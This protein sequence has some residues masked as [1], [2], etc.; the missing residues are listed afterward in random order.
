MKILVVD[1]GGIA[2]ENG[3][4]WGN[5]STANF[6]NELKE[7]GVTLTYVAGGGN[8]KK[9]SFLYSYNLTD[10][11]IKCHRVIGGRKNPLRYIRLGLLFYHI[12]KTDFV[13]IFYPGGLSKTVHFFCN[14]IGRK[15]GLYIRG[16]GS[17]KND[18]KIIKNAQF[19]TLLASNT[20]EETSK[21]NSKTRIIKPMMVFNENDSIGIKS[22][23]F[24]S[25]NKYHFL[26]IGSLKAHKGIFEIIE[27][28]K[29]FYA[30]GF[31]HTFRII[32]DSELLE[33]FKKQQADGVIPSNI[34]FK[35]ALTDKEKLKTEYLNADFLLFPTHNEGLGRVLL[36]ALMFG[37]PTYTTIV[38]GICSFMNDRVN[39]IEI[40]LKD[41]MAQAKVIL[42]TMDDTALKL[43][44]SENG[45]KT[46]NTAMTRRMSHANTVVSLI[47][48][49]TYSFEI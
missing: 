31:A 16:I 11:G 7:K 41:P 17:F 30:A 39:C 37:L 35:G 24:E 44:I 4:F 1:N 43:H 15:F 38:G 28:A 26:F 5:E 20:L 46:V 33:L 45:L 27:I 9:H 49:K 18:E 14:L 2:K 12:V 23:S 8:K 48:N 34:D 40:P 22:R 29:M 13:Y 6:L 32:G 3:V 19:I 36:E 47:K 21:Y 25:K 10:S 42:E